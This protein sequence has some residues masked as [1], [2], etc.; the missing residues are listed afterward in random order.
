M[1]KFDAVLLWVMVLSAGF[2]RAENAKEVVVAS[3]EALK[4]IKKEDHLEEGRC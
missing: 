3:T 1:K 2:V 4:G